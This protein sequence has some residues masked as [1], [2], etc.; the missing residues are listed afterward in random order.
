MQIKIKRID[1]EIP[2]PE[3]GHKGDAGFDLRTGKDITFTPNER[4]AIPTGLALEIPKGYV[5]LVWDKSG[6]AVKYGLKVLVGVIDSTYRGEVLVGMVNLSD[7]T[8]SFTK[9]DKVA[10]MVI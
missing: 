3:Y 10:Q 2:L 4:I 9:G 6:L 5:G 1:K 8:Y 7:E